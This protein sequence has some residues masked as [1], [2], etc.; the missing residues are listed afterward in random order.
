MK[1]AQ[2]LLLVFLVTGCPA[3]FSRPVPT[4]SEYKRRFLSQLAPAQITDL[5][6]SYHGAV[7]G[8]ASIA[9]FKVDADTISQIR[10]SAQLEDVY[11]SDDKDAREEFKRKIAMCAREGRIPEWFDFPF[12]KSLPVFTDSG[13]FTDEHPA[14]SHQW[15]V[16]EDRG[17]VYFVMIEG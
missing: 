13:D 10:T 14:Y 2:L 7:G 5:R 9:R 12:D 11:A 6:F 15:Y 17:I 4:E 3:P 16:D 8:E 1:H